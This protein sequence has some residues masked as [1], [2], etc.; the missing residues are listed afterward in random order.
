V[1]LTDPMSADP[2]VHFLRVLLPCAHSLD[3]LRED[4]L[5]ASSQVPLEID[6]LSVRQLLDRKEDFLLLDCREQK[7]FAVARI[8]GSQLIPMQQIPNRLVELEPFRDKQIVVHCHHG[9][10]S[11]RVAEWLRQQGFLTARNMTGGID[12]WSLEIDPTVPR[13]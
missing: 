10:R 7:E 4:S 12:A 11:L 1:E 6:V 5:M 8:A 2:G 9:G 3:N 13:Y